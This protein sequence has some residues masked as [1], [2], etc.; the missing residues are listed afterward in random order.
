M[1]NQSTYQLETTAYKL[2]TDLYYND[3]TT[4]KWST[5]NNGGTPYSAGSWVMNDGST[6]NENPP[7]SSVRTYSTGDFTTDNLG[8]SNLNNGLF[9]AT[10][11]Y[12]SHSAGSFLS[13]DPTATGDLTNSQRSVVPAG[14]YV[15]IDP[16]STGSSQDT[17]ATAYQI[18]QTVSTEQDLTGSATSQSGVSLTTLDKASSALTLVM[19]AME[20][21]R[22][23]RASLGAILQRVE[24]TTCLLYTSP[25]PRDRT[26][27]RMPSSA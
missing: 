23:D 24:Y 14:Y 2:Y 21:L 7:T 11:H 12:K 6:I 8:D 5:N 10:T 17:A 20:Q 3:S 19:N 16:T 18:G 9:T 15:A 13:S 4:P 26:R 27:S 1:T 25:S 22:I